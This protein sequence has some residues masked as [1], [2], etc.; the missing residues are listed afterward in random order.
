MYVKTVIKLHIP[1]LFCD[2]VNSECLTITL[3]HF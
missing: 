1:L 2:M 3:E